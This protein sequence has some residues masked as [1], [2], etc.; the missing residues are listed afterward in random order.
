MKTISAIIFLISF[1]IIY[2]KNVVIIGDSRICGM[3]AY[4][5]GFSYTYANAVY[6]SGSYMITNNAKNFG[7]YTIKLVAEVG[8]SYVHFTNTNKEV[9]KGVHN[10]LGSSQKGTMVF[11]WLGINNLDSGNTFDYYRSLANKYTTLTFYVVP[12]TGVSSPS[13]ITAKTIKKFNSDLKTKVNNLKLSNLKYKDILFNNDPNQIYNTDEKAITL[14]VTKGTT[15][16][17]GVHYDKK[18]Y[19]KIF[20]AMVAGI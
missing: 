9:Y 6:G 3:G 13:T 15:D 16:T 14:I 2:S 20:N 7:Q 8:A 1:I 18:G 17:M 12:V 19:Q 11:L 4:V 10:I 5:F